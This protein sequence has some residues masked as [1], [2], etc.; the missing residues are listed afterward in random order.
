MTYDVLGNERHKAVCELRNLSDSPSDIWVWKR[1]LG[2]AIGADNEMYSSINERLI[3]LLGGGV[4]PI[5][6]S[7]LFGIWKEGDGGVDAGG[8]VEACGDCAAYGADGH[9]ADS[10]GDSHAEGVAP[11]TQELRDRA[12]RYC[13]FK[14]DNI[15]KFV[16]GDFDRLCDAIDAV[17]AQLERDYKVACKVNERQDEQYADMVHKLDRAYEKNRNQRKQLTEVQEALRRRNEGE[18]KRRWMREKQDL[19]LQIAKMRLESAELPKDADDEVWR[20][21]DEL[22]DDGMVCEVVGI[23]PN[24]LYYYV[25]ATDT[26]EWTQ[27]DSRRHYHAPTVEDVL[28]E[29][30]AELDEVTALYVGEAIDSDERDRDEARIFAEYAKRLTLAGDAE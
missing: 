1:Q 2:E 21:G 11:V 14:D 10:A 15:V 20:I 9:M 25:D 18:L 23:G 29:M 3:H 28:R 4:E 8:C 26:V 19:E 24:R 7:E 16:E 30:H 17:H 27:A 12:E 13:N 5:T 22:L 6:L